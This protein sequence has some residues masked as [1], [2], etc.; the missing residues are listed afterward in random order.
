VPHFS[1]ATIVSAGGIT[2]KC[3]FWA[4][5]LKKPNLADRQRQVRTSLGISCGKSGA[6]G[7]E[8]GDFALRP[9][10]RAKSH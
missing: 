4:S 5:A 8:W 3:E 7:G 9:A 6:T 10:K 1:F 2:L